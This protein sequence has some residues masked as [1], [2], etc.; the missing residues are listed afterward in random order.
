[1][2]GMSGGM[3]MGKY[4][5]TSLLIFIASRDLY[6]YVCYENQDCSLSGSLTAQIL[7]H[8]V[9]LDLRMSLLLMNNITL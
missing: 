1:M 8:D 7:I 6:S 5:W 9:E 4:S 3:G 2:G